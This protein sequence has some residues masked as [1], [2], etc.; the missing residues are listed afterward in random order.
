MSVARRPRGGRP[1]LR[2]NAGAALVAP[3]EMSKRAIVFCGILIAALSAGADCSQSGAKNIAIAAKVTRTRLPMPAG[4]LQS[5]TELLL[6][7]IRF[8]SHPG[9]Q[10]HV[11]L[12]R[13]DDPAKRARV[14]TLSF[15]T[16]TKARTP[17]TRTFDVTDELRRIAAS[18]ADLETIDVV[19]EATTGRGG[20]NHKAAFDPES[21]LT[22]G[23]VVLR[24]SGK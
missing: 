20:A 24:V 19:F 23:E 15:Y 5:R 13:R 22:I 12:E 7:N 6:R 16:P 10:F 17:I 4:A 9:T 3:L 14:G 1:T 11:I 21:K 18:A 8:E 2:N